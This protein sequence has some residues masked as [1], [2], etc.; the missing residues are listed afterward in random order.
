MSKYIIGR[1]K[2]KLWLQPLFIFFFLHFW[3]F[4]NL[5]KM[6]STEEPK[7]PGCYC[8]IFLKT[9]D[10]SPAVQLRTLQ[11]INSNY[12]FGVKKLVTYNF[13]LSLCISC[14]FFLF[15]FYAAAISSHQINMCNSLGQHIS[16][17]NNVTCFHADLRS[18]L[19]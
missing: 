15:C 13:T 18:C 16:H 17:C 4:S 10:I 5:Y 2:K 12:C 8:K 1:K 6:F 9:A 7:D 19:I 11:C 3:L 14:F